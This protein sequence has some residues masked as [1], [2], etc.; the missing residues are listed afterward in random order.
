M[1]NRAAGSPAR[2]R[3]LYIDA[4]AGAAGDMLLGA[5]IDLGVSSRRVSSALR[6][7]PISGWKLAV[8]RVR[9]SGVAA[10]LAAVRVP[11]GAPDHHLV[12]LPGTK[13]AATVHGHGATHHGRHPAGTHPARRPGR[14]ARG[15]AHGRSWSEIRKILRSGELD[16]AVRDRALAV[17]RR[18]VEAEAAA[19]GLS[20]E[21]VHLHEA[22]A[23]D[24]L[25]DIVGCCVALDAIGPD[26]VIVSPPTTG[27]GTVA[28]AHGIYPVPG[29]ATLA[30]LEGIPLSGIAAEG[31]RLTPTGAA[32]LASFADAWGQLPAMIPE[33]TGYG[34]G[35]RD[36]SDRPNVVRVVLGESATAGRGPARVAVIE[37]DLDDSTPQAVAFACERLFEAGALDVVTCP[38]VMK[39][40]RSGHRVSVLARPERLDEVARRALEETSTLGVRYRFE[41][42]LEMDR[43]VERVTTRFGAV[44]VKVGRLAGRVVHARPEFDDCAAAARRH[45]VGLATVQQAAMEAHRKTRRE[46]R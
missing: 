46:K 44:G 3:I 12:R 27:S 15:A 31:E 40:G 9:R 13:I 45:G 20:P 34:A 24:A 28:C 38:V 4:S 41:D 8:S 1:R 21:T 6:G 33:A 23:D 16:P 22:G 11:G 14:D 7:L 10:T 42:R 36:F 5:L 39:K 18:L 35:A 37:F 43:S 26:R 29:P 17:F 30:L 25:I 2:E 32:L 19:H